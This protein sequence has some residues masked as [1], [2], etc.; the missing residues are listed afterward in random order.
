[1][2]TKAR[3]VLQD[4]K[5]AIAAHTDV[6]QSERFRVSWIAIVT[7]LRAV[8]HV[9]SKVDAETSPA[10]RSAI[11]A[12]WLELVA[13]KPEPAIFWGFIEAERNRFLKNYEHGI[14]REL[15][16]QGPV[17]DGQP[18]RIVVDVGNAQGGEFGPGKKLE[19]RISSGT[20]AGRSERE[21][22]WLAHDWW[23]EYLNAVDRLT[24]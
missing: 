10:L 3:V 6:L 8:G 16:A 24:M 13:S 15:V 5:H 17:L 11:E 2:T 9:L 23:Q 22:A 21:I 7:L 18:T 19:S 20:F 4:A 14:T 12:K 1:M